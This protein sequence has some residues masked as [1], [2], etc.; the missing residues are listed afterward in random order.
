M[1]VLER[2]SKILILLL[3]AGISAAPTGTAQEDFAAA[4]QLESADAENT[5]SATPSW[6]GG[7]FA[8]A[9]SAEYQAP[10]PLNRAF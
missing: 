5:M 2:F 7:C 1:L 3:F 10:T 8:R 6:R 9:T 4:A